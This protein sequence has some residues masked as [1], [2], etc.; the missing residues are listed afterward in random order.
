MNPA[1]LKKP[2]KIF[3]EVHQGFR[4]YLI[5]DLEL[6]ILNVEPICE[7]L[8]LGASQASKFLELRVLLEF[9]LMG[10]NNGFLLLTSFLRG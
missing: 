4:R 8:V 3:R 2:F 7:P 10:L 9:L 6:A 1:S 5:G